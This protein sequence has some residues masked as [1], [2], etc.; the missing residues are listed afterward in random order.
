MLPGHYVSV[1]RS[2]VVQLRTSYA[3][4]DLKRVRKKKESDQILSFLFLRNVHPWHVRS[5]SIVGRYPSLLLLGR[6]IPAVSLVCCH[7]Q[8]NIFPPFCVGDARISG[9]NAPTLMYM[10]CILFYMGFS[11]DWLVN[12]WTVFYRWVQFNLCTRS[13]VR[14]KLFS[15][16]DSSLPH[17]FFPSP[18]VYVIIFV[19]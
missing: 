14:G 5:C 13:S 19:S 18:L 6:L 10:S 11:A 15:S 12:S 8:K 16:S 3:Y 17:I 7:K 1:L 2:G 9:P 4:C